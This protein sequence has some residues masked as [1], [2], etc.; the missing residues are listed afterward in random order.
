MTARE[1]IEAESPKEFLRRAGIKAR[2]KAQ[3]KIPKVLEQFDQALFLDREL[4]WDTDEAQEAQDKAFRLA[5]NAGWD[6]EKA[7][8]GHFRTWCL[9]AST[10]E[11]LKEAKRLFTEWAKSRNYL[12]P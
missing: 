11:I 2:A 6:W 8:D 9:H 7:N 12:P 1:L 10:E 5:D 3:T 4:G